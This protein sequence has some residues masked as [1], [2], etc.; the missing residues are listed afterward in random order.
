[1]IQSML[2]PA[3]FWNELERNVSSKVDKAL[4][5]GDIPPELLILYLRDLEVV[6]R[7]ACDRRQ[8]IQIIASGRGVLGDRTQIG[9]TDGPFSHTIA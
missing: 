5:S 8:T 4:N 3:E 6:A 7:T 1:M 2:V 9:P